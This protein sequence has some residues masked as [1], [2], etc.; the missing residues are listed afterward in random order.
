VK[1]ILTT[2]AAIWALTFVILLAQI[3]PGAAD[4]CV[5]RD[6]YRHRHSH[7]AYV[8]YVSNYGACRVGWW[9]TLRYGHVRPRWGTWCR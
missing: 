1:R 6:H 5:R 9:Q 3:A 4:G 7:V 2:A 8:E